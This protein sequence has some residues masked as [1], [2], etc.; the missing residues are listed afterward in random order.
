MLLGAANQWFPATISVLVLPSRKE[1]KPADVVDEVMGLPPAQLVKLTSAASV[2]NWREF[3]PESMTAKFTG[4]SDEDLWQAIQVAK[5]DLPPLIPAAAGPAG[6]DPNHMLVPEWGTLTHPD[7]FLAEDRRNGFKVHPV[8]VAPTLGAVVQEVVA[9]DRIRK[10]NAFVGF[11][12][13]DALDRVGDDAARIAPISISGKPKWVPATEDR[14]EG[15]FIRFSEE[16]VA[17]WEAGVLNSEV[18]AS[19]VAA[20]ER[21][22]ARR[23]SRTA[24]E[25]DADERMP[26]P[27]YAHPRNGDVERIRFRVAVRADLRVAGGRRSRPCRGHSHHDHLAR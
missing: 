9:V 15:V 1:P 2:A 25:L 8:P 14:G 16:V 27:R 17:Q 22:L 7:D 10:A 6:Y 23:Q 11:T 24:A 5:G 13:I 21:N 12:R 26:P 18:W 20:H 4:T 19:H 3:A